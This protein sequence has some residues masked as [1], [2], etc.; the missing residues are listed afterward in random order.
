M[1]GDF[2]TMLAGHEPI[3]ALAWTPVDAAVAP[4]TVSKLLLTLRETE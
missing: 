4:W 2:E 3:L 1:N